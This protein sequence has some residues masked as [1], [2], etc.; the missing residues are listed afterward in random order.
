MCGILGGIGAKSNQFVVENVQNLHRR[1]PDSNNHVIL[2]NGLSLGA[3]RLAMTD[4]HTRSN[5]PMIDLLTKNVLVFNGEIYNYK[6][7]REKLINRNIKFNTDSDTEVLLKYLSEF[8]VDGICE[9]EGMFAF[10]FYDYA[11]NVL[12][13]ARDFLGK[14]PL[15]YTNTDKVFLFSSQAS[16]LRNY[17]LNLTLNPDAFAEYLRIG[18]IQD[19]HTIFNGV[20]AVNPGE[21]LEINLTNLRVTQKKIIFPKSIHKANNL[22]LRDIFNSSILERTDGHSHFALSMS[23]G[24]DSSLIAMQSANLGLDFTTY[25]MRFPD[26]DKERYNDDFRAAQEICRKLKVRNVVVDMPVAQEI[27]GIMNSFLSAMD[28]PNINPTG[29]S[30]MILFSR[31]A[32]DGNRLLLTGDGADEVFGGYLRYSRASRLKF[33]PELENKEFEKMMTSGNIDKKLA[34]VLY[35]FISS[36]S[37]ANWFYWHIVS[38]RRSI[39]KLT[40]IDYELKL[41]QNII[42]SLRSLI[43]SS[44]VSDLMVMDLAMYITMESNRRLDRISMWNSIEA[45]SPFQSEKVIEYGY[46]AL[47]NKKY[48]NLNK[49]IILEEFPELRDLP[50]LKEKIGF[51]SP[52][53]HWLRSNKKWVTGSLDHLNEL[54]M[55]DSKELYQ[56]SNAPYE[57]QWDKTRLLWSLVVFSQWSKLFLNKK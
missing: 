48:S 36:K 31:I 12:T 40:G 30:Q 33:I 17:S 5:Q 20:Y 26:S 35:A 38:S 1:G 27:P 46:R 50:L 51:V 2:E 24:M 49:Q 10:A 53:G 52:L 57:N 9:L 45:R 15:Y 34:K 3:T 25:T 18:Y 29:L 28:E 41:N 39:K 32:E 23:G 54:N 56:L 55:F 22:N 6:M 4:P 13:I 44:K 7:L 19:P 21:V 42:T 37:D 14:K 47:E 16:L 11:S 43:R 8:S